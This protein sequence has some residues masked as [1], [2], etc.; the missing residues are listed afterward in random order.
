MFF[1]HPV[2]FSAFETALHPFECSHNSPG[3]QERQV[4]KDHPLQRPQT[5]DQRH[6]RTWDDVLRS[7]VHQLINVCHINQ[8]HLTGLL[9]EVTNLRSQISVLVSRVPPG[10]PAPLR[11]SATADSPLAVRSAVPNVP[12]SDRPR[13]VC[14]RSGCETAVPKGCCVQYCQAHCVSPKCRM[15]KEQ[16]IRTAIVAI[17]DV[18][19]Q[20][21][22]G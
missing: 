17:Q 13:R 5:P 22:V 21:L 6:P 15:G 7:M 2:A 3:M 1:N 18:T 20:A 9:E 10:V 14:R 11:V 16:G 8:R 12:A 4:L 19:L